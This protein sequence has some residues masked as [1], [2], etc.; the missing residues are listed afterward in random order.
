M[1]RIV[2]SLIFTLPFL[3]VN[4]QKIDW[5]AYE[6][7]DG[8]F[9]RLWINP[10]LNFTSENRNDRVT[11]NTFLLLDGLY[12]YNA[13][14]ESTITNI[15]LSNRSSYNKRSNDVLPANNS[16]VQ[17]TSGFLT[18]RRYLNKRRGFYFQSELGTLIS[19]N[20]VSDTDWNNVD[21]YTPGL[22]F[23]YGRL[24]NVA[25]VYQAS[26]F[27][28]TLYNRSL[29]QSGLFE[30]ADMIRSLEYNNKL[31]TRMRNIENETAFLNY[32]ESTGYDL[33]NNLSIVQ[34]LDQYRFERP[35]DLRHGYEISIGIQKEFSI[36][37]SDSELD[38]TARAAWAN[39]LSDTWHLYSNVRFAKMIEGRTALNFGANLSYLPS[40]RTR[41]TF[42][43][44]VNQIWIDGSD[45]FSSSS[46]LNIDYFVSPRLSI[47]GNI[48]YNVSNPNIFNANK[49]KTFRT[50]YGIFYYII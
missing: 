43:Q 8:S 37:N 42:S 16:F 39:A 12:Q 9:S 6:E 24:E 18:H 38:F 28:K 23:G 20:K 15:T 40:A 22:T 32:L 35:F 3:L 33:S 49:T 2:I 21:S 25:T 29:D 45:V 4:G 5:S 36:T 11:K 34:A 46:D 1:K 14:N 44:F 7:P 30:M 26:R 48:S 19:L 10:Q 17:N 47:F 41:I 27:N 50:R 13:L 31:D